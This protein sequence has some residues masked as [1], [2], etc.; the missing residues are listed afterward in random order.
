VTPQPQIE[1]QQGQVDPQPSGAALPDPSANIQRAPW[2][3]TAAA[4]PVFPR[5]QYNRP[6]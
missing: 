2:Q 6:A 4:L 1:P 3:R 5:N